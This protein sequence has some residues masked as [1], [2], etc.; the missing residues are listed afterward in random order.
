MVILSSPLGFA[1]S[2]IK[3]EEIEFPQDLA[4]CVSYVGHPATKLLLEVLGAKTLQGL[5]EGP[6]IEESYIAVPLARNAREDG[7]TRD[8]AVESTRELRAIRFTRI[9]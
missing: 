7:W 8:V 2:T 1:G 4:G 3:F 9:A 5:W 6:R